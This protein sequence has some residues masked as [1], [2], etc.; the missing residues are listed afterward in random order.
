MERLNRRR[1]GASGYILRQHEVRKSVCKSLAM[2]E[3]HY[4]R[5]LLG[6]PVA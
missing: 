2:E 1:T 3:S 4:S 6:L 5:R